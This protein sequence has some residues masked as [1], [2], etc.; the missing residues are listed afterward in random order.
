MLARHF[1]RVKKY[2]LCR[3][4]LSGSALKEVECFATSGGNYGIDNVR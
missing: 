1:R 3:G 2:L 4:I